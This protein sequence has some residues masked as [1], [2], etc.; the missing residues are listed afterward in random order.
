MKE[1][2]ENNTKKKS[3]FPPG[4]GKFP[5]VVGKM[6][7]ARYLQIPIHRTSKADDSS[8]KGI[9]ISEKEQPDLKMKSEHNLDALMQVRKL[10]YEKSEI[11]MPMCLVEGPEDA[12][13]VDEQ[14]NAS[15]NSSIPKG[16][17]LLTATHEIISMYGL[18]YYM[19]N[20]RS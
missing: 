13:Y 1:F 6:G 3:D 17:V 7:Y 9:F 5:Y 8:L 14:G 15:G 18:H 11:Y 20:V 2:N 4:Y 19:P 12:I 16:G 10:H